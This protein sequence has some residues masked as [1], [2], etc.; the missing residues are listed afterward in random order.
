MQHNA[1]TNVERNQKQRKPPHRYLDKA[2]G[3]TLGREAQ[4]QSVEEATRFRKRRNTRRN[5]DKLYRIGFKF[6]VG[7]WENIVFIKIPS[8]M[9]DTTQFIQ[10]VQ[11]NVSKHARGLINEHFLTCCGSD[12]SA[13]AL[14]YGI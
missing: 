4:L 6:C 10:N 14:L 12:S 1:C 2:R 8:G 5:A 9:K 13:V 7:K 3:L 11:I